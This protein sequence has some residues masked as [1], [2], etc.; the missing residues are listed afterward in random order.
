[1]GQLVKSTAQSISDTNEWIF[2]GSETSVANLF[3][4]VDEGHLMETASTTSDLDIQ[5]YME[6]AMYAVLMPYAW[7]LSNEALH[8]FVIDTG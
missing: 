1:M 6:Q 7:S 8:P 5:Q 2:N 4:M 3:R